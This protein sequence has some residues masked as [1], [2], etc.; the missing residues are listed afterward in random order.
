MSSSSEQQHQK[1]PSMIRVTVSEGAKLF[2]VTPKT[3]RMALKNGELKYVVVRGRY[4][5]SFA[6]L[7]EWSQSTARRAAKVKKDGIGQFVNQW[8]I[9]NPKY[10]PNPKLVRPE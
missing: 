9:S 3:I 6:S 8:K 10:S 2:G 7:V 4:K 1:I 5:I